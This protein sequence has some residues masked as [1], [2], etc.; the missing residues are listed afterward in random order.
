MPGRDAPGAKSRMPFTSQLLHF[1]RRAGTERS[2]ARVIAEM[3]QFVGE[4]FTVERVSLHLADEE[5]G[6]LEPY[7]SQFASGRQDP[8]LYDRWRAFDIGS[9]G[10]ARRIGGGEDTVLVE[11]PSAGD[12]L[13]LRYVQMF[14]VDPFLAVALRRRG[15]LEG[16]LIIEGPVETLRRRQDDA[17]EFAGYLTLALE[18]ARAFEREQERAAEAHALLEVVDVL[19]RTTDLVAVLAAVTRQCAE[20]TGFERCSVFLVDPDTNSLVPTMS[21]FADGHADPAAWERFRTT[22]V[23]LPIAWEVIRSGEPAAF[24]RPE[25]HPDLI[26]PEWLEPFGIQTALY[27]PLSAWGQRFGVLCLDNRQRTDI[28]KRQLRI[29]QGVAAQG[30]VAIG[31]T[32]ALDRERAATAE[33]GRVNRAKDEFLSMVSHEMRTPLSSIHGFADLLDR[34]HDELDAEERREMARRIRANA[35]RQIELIDDLLSSDRL[36]NG[37]IIADRRHVQLRDLVVD[38]VDAFDVD[39]SEV[40]IDVDEDH[41][42]LA[43]PGHVRQILTNLLSNADRYGRPPFEISSVADADGGT[44]R[45]RVRDRGAGIPDEFVPHLFERFTQADRDGDSPGI[46]LGLSIA[47]QMARANDG[48]VVH[49]EV[50]DGACFALTLPRFGRGRA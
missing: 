19:S 44:V 5:T 8:E 4:A 2:T 43:D 14:D 46:G 29:T 40:Q 21:Q 45:L 3:F 28:T 27:L 17:A 37:A 39:R 41:D 1:L 35:D 42:V 49:E 15:R 18:N 47:R 25:D 13:P 6:G 11:D 26:P 34:R 23:D 22:E 50:D 16:L 10:L 9:T 36:A 31:V 48:E 30:A 38:T 20:V 7:V 12:V 32:R 24:E 33:L